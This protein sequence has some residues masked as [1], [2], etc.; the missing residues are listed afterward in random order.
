MLTWRIKID[1]LDVDLVDETGNVKPLKIFDQLRA[2]LFKPP[3]DNGRRYLKKIDFRTFESKSID[4]NQATGLDN[5][6]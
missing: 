2:A 6:Q 5:R 3:K 4:R 1:F